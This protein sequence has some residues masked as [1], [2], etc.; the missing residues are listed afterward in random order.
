MSDVAKEV[1]AKGERKKW[2]IGIFSIFLLCGIVFSI[3]NWFTLLEKYKQN[4]VI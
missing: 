3:Y 2:G 1:R 4:H